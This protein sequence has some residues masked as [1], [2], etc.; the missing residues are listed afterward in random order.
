MV[1]ASCGP[2]LRGASCGSMTGGLLPTELR[3]WGAGH[4]LYRR[5][6]MPAAR[7]A[8]RSRWPVREWRGPSPRN[9][10]QPYDWLFAAD[11]SRASP[12]SAASP[13]GHAAGVVSHPIAVTR[14]SP[15][16]MVAVQPRIAGR[17][18]S[19]AARHPDH[20]APADQR[21][22]SRPRRRSDPVNRRTPGQVDQGGSM[23]APTTASAQ[24]DRRAV[25]QAEQRRELAADDPEQMSITSA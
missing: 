23:T 8:A 24:A 10:T 5:P 16:E 25:L 18:G 7:R 17:S 4:Q 15:V 22:D 19:R 1:G 11:R 2:R 21:L 13:N 12:P 14:R 3:G 9:A 20:R 6:A